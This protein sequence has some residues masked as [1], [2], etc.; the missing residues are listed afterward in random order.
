MRTR[1]LEREEWKGDGKIVNRKLYL[2]LNMKS[3][4]ILN[5]EEQDQGLPAL[6]SILTSLYSSNAKEISYGDAYQLVYKLC[7]KGMADQI[8]QE[9]I[10]VSEASFAS[11]FEEGKDSSKVSASLVS[12]LARLR[13]SMERVM[14]VL[15]YLETNY[16]QGIKR[17][18]SSI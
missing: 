16:F 1:V 15:L 11:F 9:L 18:Y 7:K 8:I 12:R 3:E 5:E 17:E 4:E 14:E 10:K 6:T 2:N 13:E